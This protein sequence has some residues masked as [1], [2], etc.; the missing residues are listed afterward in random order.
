MNYILK[1]IV[2]HTAYYWNGDLFGSWS[3]G[4]NKAKRYCQ[5]DAYN[6]RDGLAF[7][8]GCSVGTIEVVNLDGDTPDGQAVVAQTYCGKAVIDA[9]E[10]KRILRY[11]NH[12]GYSMPVEFRPALSALGAMN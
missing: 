7:L 4:K 9:D 8:C 10:L 3:V 11:A 5:R 1:T 6:V 12:A 2:N